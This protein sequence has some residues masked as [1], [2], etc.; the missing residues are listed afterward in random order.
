MNAPMNTFKIKTIA[1]IL[2][3]TLSAVSMAQNMS[4]EDYKAAKDTIETDFKS[5]KT[6]CDPMSANAKDICVAEAKGA[7][8][9]AKAELEANFKP[10]DRNRRGALVAK[11]DAEYEAAKERC[12][13]MTGD[14]KG[15]CV[16]DAQA[17]RSA[18]K[19]EAKTQKKSAAD[20]R[21][22]RQDKTG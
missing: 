21:A 13:D 11:A 17:A 8:K 7:Q 4:K 14:A 18:A 6:R 12:D 15:L 20:S 19:N 1:L 3:C 10:T 5:A 9:V 16:K 22:S 2:G